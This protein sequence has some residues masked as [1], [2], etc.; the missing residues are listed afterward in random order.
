[1]IMLDGEPL[2]RCPRRPIL[3]EPEYFIDLFEDLY[4]FRKGF[5]PNE[6]TWLDQSERFVKSIH[7]FD[8]YVDKGSDE[9]KRLSDA[10]ERAKDQ[11]NRMRGQR[12]F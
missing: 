10:R 12:K 3:D 7:I 5:L 11:A 9:K 6:G 4:W 1:M 2:P 8:R